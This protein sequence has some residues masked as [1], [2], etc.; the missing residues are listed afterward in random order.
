MEGTVTFVKNKFPVANSLAGPALETVYFRSFGT[1]PL[2]DRDSE[3]ELGKEID[4]ATRTIRSI[5][6]Q[7]LRLASGQKKSASQLELICH[8]Q[9]DL[10]TI[11]TLS[12]SH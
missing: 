10:S 9:G 3:V 8:T 6:K 5:L 7:G 2:L 11:W 4:Q 12:S 1:G